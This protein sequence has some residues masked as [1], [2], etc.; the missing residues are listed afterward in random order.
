MFSK[1]NIIKS[2]DSVNLLGKGTVITGDLFI[3]TDLRIDGKLEG[4]L[5]VKGRLVLGPEGVIIGNVVAG[6]ADISGEIKGDLRVLEILHLKQTCRIEGDMDCQKLLVDAGAVFN[7]TC[8]MG[9]KMKKLPDTIQQEEKIY[10]S[11]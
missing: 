9:A 11:R 8:R 3:E 1:K 5:T 4:N 7:G 10:E 2:P 6:Q